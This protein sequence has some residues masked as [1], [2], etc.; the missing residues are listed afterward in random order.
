MYTFFVATTMSQ[1]NF[2]TCTMSVEIASTEIED[3][4]TRG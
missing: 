2:E 4:S 1:I 3:V